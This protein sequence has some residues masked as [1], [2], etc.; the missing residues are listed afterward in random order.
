[1]ESELFLY[2]S[3]DPDPK[4]RGFY[5]PLRGFVSGKLYVSIEI[6]NSKSQNPNKFQ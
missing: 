6:P 1:M 2:Q 3:K 4:G 5:Y